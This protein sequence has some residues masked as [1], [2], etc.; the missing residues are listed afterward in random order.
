MNARTT[1]IFENPKDI[2]KVAQLHTLQSVLNGLSNL[3]A[4][5]KNK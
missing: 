4:K 5:K 2:A 3:C 1:P